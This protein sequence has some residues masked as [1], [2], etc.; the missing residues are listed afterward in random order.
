MLPLFVQAAGSSELGASVHAALAAWHSDGGDLLGLYHGPDAGKAILAAYLAH[1]LAAVP[2]LGVEVEF[3]M[4][5]GHASVRGFV[6]RV[7]EVDGRTVLVDYKTNAT[8]DARLI[9]AYSTQLRLYAV[10]ARRGLVP[11]GPEP[12]LALF[13]MR[14]AALIEVTPDEGAVEGRI[15][16][17]TARISAGDFEL[18]PE[19]ADRPCHLCAFR[20]ICADARVPASR[21]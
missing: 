8:L 6:D 9:E 13:D 16:A 15:A 11:G 4:R 7:C 10:A 14:R 19:H 17:A 3:N 5:L 2:T 1:P 20:P 18:G 12:R 21:R